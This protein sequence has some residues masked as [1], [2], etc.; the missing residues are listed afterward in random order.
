MSVSQE[1]KALISQ[2]PRPVTLRTVC[3]DGTRLI[4]A[5]N[6]RVTLTIIFPAGC[7]PL[8]AITFTF[9]K[10]TSGKREDCRRV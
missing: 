6:G 8:S 5:S 7:R 10:V 3:N 1:R 9:G 2:L 4:A